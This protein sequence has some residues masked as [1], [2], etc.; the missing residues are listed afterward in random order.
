MAYTKYP[1]FHREGG[2]TVV[3]RE[4]AELA[5]GP[6]REAPIGR[7][8]PPSMSS[9]QLRLLLVGELEEV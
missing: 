7:H 5:G 8:L 3:S 1:N 9:V 4:T 2:V 6:H